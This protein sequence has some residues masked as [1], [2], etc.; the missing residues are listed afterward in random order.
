M[1]WSE[2]RSGTPL[3]LDGVAKGEAEVLSEFSTRIR[4]L[5][6][7]GAIGLSAMSETRSGGIEASQSV[8]EII[9]AARDMFS[10]AWW[11]GGGEEMVA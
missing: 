2:P 11:G 3:P 9:S 10:D 4:N 1:S 8:A 6:R 5:V 7:M